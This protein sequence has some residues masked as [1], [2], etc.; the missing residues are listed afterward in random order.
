LAQPDSY[1][2]LYGQPAA[3]PVAALLSNDSDP[4]GDA[5]SITSV[6]SVSAQGFPLT[7]AGGVISYVPSTNFHGSDSFAYTI[8]DGYGGQATGAVTINELGN[9][10]SQNVKIET[11]LP[12]GSVRLRFG[13]IPGFSYTIQASS[14]LEP[15]AWTTLGHATAGSNGEF[16]FTDSTAAGQPSRF[17]RSA[18][19]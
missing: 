12:D 11:I 15:P 2:R 17:Y 6:S 13:G 5:L 1:P 19:P 3:I 4:D 10:L 8:S 14:S 7:L 18:Y 9:G 16:S